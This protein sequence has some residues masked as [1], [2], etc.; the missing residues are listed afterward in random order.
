MRWQFWKWHIHRCRTEGDDTGC[1]GECIVCGQRF[2]FVTREDLRAYA[3]REVNRLIREL[4][5]TEEE[6]DRQYEFNAGQIVKVV[7]LEE[8]VRQL[9]EA[10]DEIRWSNDSRWQSDRAIAALTA[11]EP[12]GTE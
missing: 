4:F 8:Q 6:R 12:R 3:D 5:N 10:L 2:G 9:R 7:A 1:W 11:T